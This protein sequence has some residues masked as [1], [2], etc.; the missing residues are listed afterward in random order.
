[1]NSSN[2]KLISP[3]LK[4]DDLFKYDVIGT[5]FN[6]NYYRGFNILI[7]F[8]NDVKIWSAFV[9]DLNYESFI[10]FAKAVFEDVI[11]SK[12]LN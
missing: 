7:I 9:F 8:Y 1:M 12:N 10:K 2:F 11:N 3:K 6:V 5:N 4:S